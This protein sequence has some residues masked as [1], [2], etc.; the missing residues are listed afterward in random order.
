MN[1]S[2]LLFC[3]IS[4]VITLTLEELLDKPSSYNPSWK[5]RFMDRQT[6]DSDLLKAAKTAQG[7]NDNLEHEA[8]V[9]A[10]LEPIPHLGEFPTSLKLDPSY[11]HLP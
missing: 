4:S 2:I 10:D 7:F 5:Q 9:V 11:D 3:C 6:E 1:I 8:R